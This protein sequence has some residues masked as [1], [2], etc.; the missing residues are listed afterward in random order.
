MKRQICHLDPEIGYFLFSP[1]KGLY[2]L[3]IISSDYL[4]EVVSMVYEFK[5]LLI[6][7]SLIII[8]ERHNDT[9]I[10]KSLSSLIATMVHG[11]CLC[12]ASRLLYV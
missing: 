10:L 2:A 4:L 7:A 8:R 5:W 6:P 1:L 9:R 11:D 3:V 12:Q